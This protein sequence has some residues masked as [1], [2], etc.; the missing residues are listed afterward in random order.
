[1]LKIGDFSRLSMISIRMLRYFD[2]KDVLKPYKIDLENNYRYYLESQLVT[3]CKIK[4]LQNMGFT[5]S[6]IKNILLDDSDL[7]KAVLNQRI[8]LL[9][10]QQNIISSINSIDLLLVKINKG[11][12]MNYSVVVKEIPNL[13]VLSY[14]T[15]INKY[16]DE[17]ILWREVNNF[18]VKNNIKLAEPCYPMAIFHDLEYKENNI[19]VE[20]QIAIEKECE[21]SNTVKF[22][23]RDSLK[24][25]SITF[26]G[27][28]SQIQYINESAA[29]YALTNGLKFT[30]P[31]FNI[32][33]I[34]PATE[35]NPDNYITESCFP[36]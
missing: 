15:K 22:L 17:F 28:Y 8:K 13:N 25:I 35:K 31:M 6:E 4:S 27:D 34:S 24:V 3:A 2:E 5:I 12:N 7:E 29:N 20:V 10:E 30:G 32:Y 14:R 33:H 21:S 11:E 26:K 23:N 19:D 1:M 18:I 36:I 9:K 16:E